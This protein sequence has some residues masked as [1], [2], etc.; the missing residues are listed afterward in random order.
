[1]LGRY[2]F[3]GLQYRKR[4]VY[5]HRLRREDS[6]IQGGE[7]RQTRFH[8]DSRL[9]RQRRKNKRDVPPVR[10]MPSGACGVL[11]VRFSGASRDRRK[12]ISGAETL[13]IAAVFVQSGLHERLIYIFFFGIIKVTKKKYL[14]KFTKKH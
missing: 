14:G 8:D 9:R 5:P 11:P 3:Y 7:R 12:R 4:I 13:R 1:M 6:R 2:C 10:R